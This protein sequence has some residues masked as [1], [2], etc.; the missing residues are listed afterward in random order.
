MN[1]K[2][3]SL[4]ESLKM[5]SFVFDLIINPKTEVKLEGECFIIAVFY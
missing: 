2:F 3:R 1:S 5:N 4:H